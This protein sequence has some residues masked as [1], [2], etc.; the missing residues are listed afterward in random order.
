MRLSDRFSGLLLLVVAVAIALLARTFHATPGHPVGPGLFPLLLGGGLGLCGLVL[1]WTGHGQTEGR[2]VVWEE[3]IRRPRL[4]LNFALVTGALVFYA[5][6]VDVVGFFLC[7]FLILTAL[8]LAFD[9]NRRW[10]A[11]LA[12]AVTLLLHV[13][14]YTLLRVPLPWGW[15]EGIA[16]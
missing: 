4:V 2:M 11:P 13:V 6:A 5:L 8:F 3:W 7:A 12:V 14:F 15:L 10:I 9:V 1:V 16:W